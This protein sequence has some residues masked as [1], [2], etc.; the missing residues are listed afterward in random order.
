MDNDKLLKIVTLFFGIFFAGG[1]AFAGIISYGSLI[2]TGGQNSDSGQQSGPVTLPSENYRVGEY[3]LT[4]RERRRLAARN[5]VVFASLLYQ[6]SEEKSRLE[7][8]KGL[9]NNFNGRMFLEVVNSSETTKF[10]T[11]GNSTPRA[12]LISA[13]RNAAVVPEPTEDSVASATCSSLLNW[14][15]VAS[16]CTQYQ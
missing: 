4:M 7:Q 6:N 3:D 11:M 15:S 13:R 14:G 16:Y 10:I 8:L 12:V 9:Q 2:S 5:D 1:F